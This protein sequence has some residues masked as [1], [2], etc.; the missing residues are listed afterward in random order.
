MKA[1][2]IGLVKNAIFWTAQPALLAVTSSKVE[3]LVLD[4]LHNHSNH[5]LIGG[6]LQHFAGKATVPDSAICRSRF[7]KY[8][9]GLLPSLEKILDALCQYNDLIHG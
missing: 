5:V 6:K 4:K 9:T 3:T 2:V 1:A 8:D 7:D